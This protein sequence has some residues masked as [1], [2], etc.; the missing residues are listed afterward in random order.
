MAGYL[1]RFEN[2]MNNGYNNAAFFYDRLA[3]LVFGN[4]LQQAQSLFLHLIPKDARVLIVGGGSGWI[5]EELARIHPSSKLSITYVE[6]APKMVELAQ[7]RIKSNPALSEAPFLTNFITA[8]IQDAQLDGHY[9]VIITAFFFD[10]FNDHEAGNIVDKLLQH[11]AAR[12][13]W[14]YT[15]FRNSSVTSHKLLLKSMYL[16]FALICG[17]TN[18]RLPDMFRIFDKHGLVAVHGKELMNGFIESAVYIN[19]I[20]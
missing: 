1:N 19:N 4:K 8:P 11:F 5:L 13:Q 7:Q 2:A 20:T 3:R 9:D 6:A 16:F 17:L 14:F 12:G 18:R 15:D 10:N